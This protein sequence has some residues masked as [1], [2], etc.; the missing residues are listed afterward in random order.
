M[1]V[2]KYQVRKKV[3]CQYLKHI[4]NIVYEFSLNKGL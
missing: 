3:N 2:K 1:Q 4:T